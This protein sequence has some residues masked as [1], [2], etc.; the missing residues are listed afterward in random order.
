MVWREAGKLTRTLHPNYTNN[1]LHYLVKV[2]NDF[3]EKANTLKTLLVYVSLI[4]ELLVVGDG[5][6]H[7]TDVMICL[8]V[9]IIRT[10]S[11]VRN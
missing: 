9:E 5:G 11:L 6:K 10:R 8:G 2:T 3:I 4:V 1:S 7:Y